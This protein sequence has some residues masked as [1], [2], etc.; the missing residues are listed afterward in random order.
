MSTTAVWLSVAIAVYA[1]LMAVVIIADDRDPQATITWLFLL[2][3]LPGVGLLFYLLFGRDLAKA[4]E[5]RP[6]YRSF[7]ERAEEALAA[8]AAP[9]VEVRE[10]FREGVSGSLAGQVSRSIS[11]VNITVPM[12]A[13]EFEVL[14]TGAEAFDRLLADL[15]SAERFVHMQYFIWERDELTS[16]ITEVLLDRLR[17]GVEVR[18]TYDWIASIPFRKDELRRLQAAGAKRTAD[19]TSITHLNYRNHRKMTIID[20]ENSYTGGINIGQEYIDGGMKFPTWRDTMVRFTGPA[21]AQLEALFAARWYDIFRED[22]LGEKY[23]PAVDPSL[24][25]DD[26]LMLQVVYQGV[27]DPWSSSTRAYQTAISRARRHVRLASPYFIPDEGT[28]DALI[29]AALAGVDVRFLMTGWPDHKLAFWAAKTYWPK[30]IE[31]GV[32]V[33]TYS[34]GFYHSKSLTV[35]GEVCAIGTMNMDI[36]SLRLH[37]ELM[38][39]V[40]DADVTHRQERIFDDD[41]ANSDAVTAE[42]IA[43]FTP[44]KHFGYSTA[45]LLSNTM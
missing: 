29:D 19:V 4:V 20:N 23:M 15:A 22:L 25:T 34:A 13:R 28:Y 16:R 14:P 11:A 9:Y 10:R 43:A 21:V 24:Q 3:V 12:P 6:E 41:L 39:W 7:M 2:I 31:A 18:I 38:A 45:R 36:R 30:L 42:T 26:P 1:V 33:Y 17:H 5:R 8:A 40:Y 35:D 32:H 27:E 37:K 44:L